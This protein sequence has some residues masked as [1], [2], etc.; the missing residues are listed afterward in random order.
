MPRPDRTLCTVAFVDAEGER[1]SHTTMANT[2][3]EA[4]RNAWRWFQSE[5]WTRGRP[6]RETIFQLTTPSRGT[7]RVKAAHALDAH[8]QQSPLFHATKE[9]FDPR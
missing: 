8:P 1:W 4:V 7:Y 3:F 6:T 9:P 5:Q 2:T